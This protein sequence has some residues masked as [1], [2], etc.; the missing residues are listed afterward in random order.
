VPLSSTPGDE[1]GLYEWSE[2]QLQLVTILPDAEGGKPTNGGSLGFGGT[3]DRSVSN[4]GSR[5]FW[6]AF[7]PNLYVRDTVREE[8][9]HIG[10]EGDGGNQLGAEYQTASSDGSRVFYTD[11]NGYGKPESLEVCEVATVAEKMACNTTQLAPSV[12][13]NVLGA[14]EDGSTVYFISNAMLAG[15]AVSG[16]CERYASFQPPSAMCN[17]YV[18][19][20]GGSAWEAPK[21]VA[22]LSAADYAD[23]GEGG[24]NPALMTARVSPDGRWLAFMSERSLTGY[25]NRD[26]VSGEADEEVYLYNSETAKLVCASCDPTG[27]RPVGSEYKKVNG[28]DGGYK[29]WNSKT[30]LASN[31]PGWTDY[32]LGRGIY[33]SR[34]LSNGGRLF[35][36]SRDALVPQDVNGE[37][38]VYE[39]EP[40]GVGGCTASSAT[41]SSRSGG[42]AGLVS[43]GASPERSGF[44]DAS[45]DGDD[46]FFLTSGKLVP[47]DVDTSY[48][49]YDAHVCSAGAPCLVYPTVPPPCSTGDSCKAAP[50]PQPAIFGAPASS[51]FS[52]VGD[53]SGSSKS[54]AT[55]R[56]LSRPQKLARALNACRSKPRK[57][58]R[59]CEKAARRRF[60]A[61]KSGNARTSGG[62]HR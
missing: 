59:S 14:S 21:L 9:L 15:G 26:A 28:L 58:R 46:V 2:G 62:G 4:N 44:L 40:A 36:N 41:F 48:D 50:T 35:F 55:P 47:E 45:G 57:K 22:V 10:S 38:D 25:D 51:T 37:W 61:K 13:G 53:L 52:G 20:Y 43:S 7:G 49:V 18:A 39:F 12:L 31:I 3:V 17:L 60:A 6:G 56:S 16:T 5:V 11:L 29:V 33:Q 23:W 8:T 30:W 34:Y 42:C 27:A 54:G 24:A 32:T 1:G 19:H